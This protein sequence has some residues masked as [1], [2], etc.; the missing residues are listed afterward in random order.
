MTRT[1]V[2]PAR[3]EGELKTPSRRAIGLFSFY[4][5]WY[6]RRHFH[7]VR[8]ANAGRIPPLAQPL[9]LFCNHASWWDPLASMLLA[10]TILPAR[11]HY[12][13]VDSTVLAHYGIFR[14]MGFFPVD[15]RSSRGVAQLLRAG[16]QV[17]SRPGA[18]LWVTPE[19]QI[20]DVRQRPIISGPGWA[21]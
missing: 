11:Q 13:P 3:A 2:N 4:L 15:N 6:L 8:V 17:L 16:D 20:Q 5:R 19:D 18:V 14:P 12:A 9:I 7:R 10:Q 21:R 1:Q